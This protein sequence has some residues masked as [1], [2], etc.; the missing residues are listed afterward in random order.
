M[1]LVLTSPSAALYCPMLRA[2]EF[3]EKGNSKT[4][5]LE[6]ADKDDCIVQPDSQRPFFL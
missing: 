2:G 1:P 4:I 6:M 3:T 5:L